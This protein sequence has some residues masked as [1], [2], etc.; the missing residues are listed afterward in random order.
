MAA[1][2]EW[3]RAIEDLA[4]TSLR[5]LCAE[6]KSAIHFGECFTL[7][8]PARVPFFK[9]IISHGRRC[10]RTMQTSI[11]M[12]LYAA[13]CNTMHLYAAIY[14]YMQL[15]TCS[16]TQLNAAECILCNYTVLSIC[17]RLEILIWNFLKLYAYACS[18]LQLYAC[19]HMKLYASICRWMQLC[20]AICNYMQLCT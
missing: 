8:P 17:M 9:Q 11:C 14:S 2:A 16:Y 12:W 6:K 5:L 15:Y 13:I 20:A 10:Y 19:R 3:W 18:L 4:I 7:L 1:S